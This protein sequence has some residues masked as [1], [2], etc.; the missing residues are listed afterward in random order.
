MADALPA[1]P[2]D[3]PGYVVVAML[4]FAIVALLDLRDRR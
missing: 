4:L 1:L 2:L 3:H